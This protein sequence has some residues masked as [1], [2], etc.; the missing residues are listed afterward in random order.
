MEK[1]DAQI[2]EAAAIADELWPIVEANATL[3]HGS[4]T[5]NPKPQT[6]TPTH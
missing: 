4:Y 6:P 1:A 5:Q 2:T 3:R